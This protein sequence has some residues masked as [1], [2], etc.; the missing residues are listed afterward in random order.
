[1]TT[2]LTTSVVATAVLW[3]SVNATGRTTSYGREAP[4]WTLRPNPA[5][6][7]LPVRWHGGCRTAGRAGSPSLQ[8]AL[9]ESSGWPLMASADRAQRSPAPPD[10]GSMKQ[11][12]RGRSRPR[13]AGASRRVTGPR[14][15][16]GRLR[17]RSGVRRGRDGRGR[18][19]AAQE[20]CPVSQGS[21]YVCSLLGGARFQRWRA[22]R[23]GG[24]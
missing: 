13:R 6:V 15:R 17:L 14:H 12:E 16:R 23:A 11:N 22:S 5:A 18:A 19:D 2:R 7:V 21:S 3:S 4:S 9:T 20:C 24:A 1:L 10:V 8:E